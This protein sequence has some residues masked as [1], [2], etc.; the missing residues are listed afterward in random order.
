MFVQDCS[1]A[2][3]TYGP[4]QHTYHNSVEQ[5][6]APIVIITDN[7]EKGELGMNILTWSDFNITPLFRSIGGSGYYIP[8]TCYSAD[9]QAQE[10]T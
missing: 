2:T 10:Q 1:R 6:S 9:F 8:F 3:R 5:V 7:I 4:L